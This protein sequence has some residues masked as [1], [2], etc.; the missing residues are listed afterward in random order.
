MKM[1]MIVY[2]GA[3][4][5]RISSLLDRHPAGGYTECGTGHGAGASGRR[6][7]SRAWPGESTVLFSIVPADRTPPLV[8]ALRDEA[9]TLPRGERMHVAVLAT[10]SFF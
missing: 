6:A 9:A 3:D 10:E 4:P 5:R 7:G 1:V 8:D 2:S